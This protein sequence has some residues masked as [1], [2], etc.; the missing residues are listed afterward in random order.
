MQCLY[1]SLQTCGHVFLICSV[2]LLSA[3]VVLLFFNKMSNKQ[4]IQRSKNIFVY[5]VP[6]RQVMLHKDSS[7]NQMEKSSTLDTALYT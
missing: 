5:Q 6:E 7:V 3:E 1:V 2:S 4:Y